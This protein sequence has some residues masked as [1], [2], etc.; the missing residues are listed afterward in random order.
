MKLQ[1]FPNNKQHFLNLP[2]SL[3]EGLEWKKGDKITIKIAG[4]NKIMLEKE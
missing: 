2:K 3:I 4:K 1:Q